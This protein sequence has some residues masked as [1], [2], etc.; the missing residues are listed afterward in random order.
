MSNKN[1]TFNFLLSCTRENTYLKKELYVRT[2]RLY[3]LT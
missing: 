1:Y 2:S 3:A